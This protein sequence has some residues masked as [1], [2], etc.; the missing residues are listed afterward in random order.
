MTTFLTTDDLSRSLWASG[1]GALADR[2]VASVRPA[3]EFVRQQLP[4]DPLPAG[5]SK[6]G[7]HPDLPA[8]FAW[9]QRGP[10][11]DAEARA[12][13]IRRER[14]YFLA[15][16]SFRN[17]ADHVSKVFDGKAAAFSRQLPLAFVAQLNLTQ[18][19]LEAGYPEDFPETGLL[20]IFSDIT[21]SALAVLLFEDTSNLAR[22]RWPETLV[23][24]SD[25]FGADAIHSFSKKWSARDRAEVLYPVSLLTVPYHW[26]KAYPDGSATEGKLREWFYTEKRPYDYFPDIADVR[27]PLLGDPSKPNACFGDRLG[28]WPEDIQDNPEIDVGGSVE[29]PGK[30]R[31]RHIFSY[32]AENWQDTRIMRAEHTAD[33]NTFLMMLQDDLDARRFDRVQNSY[34]QT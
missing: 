8:D 14:D 10:L 32:G 26:L 6:I 9:P 16:D 3:I 33:G 25:R 17:Q 11:P 29:G 13:S 4:D 31:W 18:L 19:S 23:D 30:T 7:G 22:R 1:L 15:S 12:K 2:M 34:Q 27:I 5:V 20:S 21:A 28:G 24:Y